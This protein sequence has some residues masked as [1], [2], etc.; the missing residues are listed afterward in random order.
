[1]FYGG[2]RATKTWRLAQLWLP[3]CWQRFFS[4]QAERWN[5]RGKR[6]F[7]VPWIAAACLLTIPLFFVR[8]YSTPTRSMENT[9]LIG[10]RFLARVYPAF[11]PARGDMLIFRQQISPGPSSVLVKRVVGIPGDRIHMTSRTLYV[12][13]SALTEPYVVHEDRRDNHM[14]DNFPVDRAE[15]IAQARLLV[16][17][18]EMADARQD[19]VLNHVEGADVVVPAGK[20]FVLGDNRD[21]SLDSRFFGFVDQS[22]VVGKPL[23]IYDSEEPPQ[24]AGA[25][26]WWPKIRWERLFRRL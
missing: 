14:R 12:N 16:G 25:L 23:L 26:V 2:R 22:D 4:W 18:A 8:A 15:M 20:Y 9:L 10:D 11:T 24:M 19:M 21:N 6:G 17:S 7:A 1:M 5:G 13:G 3:C